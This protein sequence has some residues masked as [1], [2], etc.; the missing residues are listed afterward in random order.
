ME[1]I[2]KPAIRGM[3][4]APAIDFDKNAGICEIKGESFLEETSKFYE[5]LLKWIK[6][7][8]ETGRPITLNL[9]LIYFNT[10]TAKWILNF[11]HSL[12]EYENQGNEVVINWYYMK[13][14]IDMRE[15]I[16]DYELDSGLKINKIE[17]EDETFFE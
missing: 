3:Y 5:P 15:E 16:E 8:M 2:K 13:G 4:I 17:I 1:S 14:D 10:S 9:K 12:K 7:F 11:L 6:E